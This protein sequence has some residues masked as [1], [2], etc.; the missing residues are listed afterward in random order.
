MAT[1]KKTLR[2]AALSLTVL[3]IVT[4]GLTACGHGD[5]KAVPT[6]TILST[7]SMGSSGSASVSPSASS[8]ASGAAGASGNGTA[9]ATAGGSPAPGS[10]TSAP[11]STAIFTAPDSQQVPPRQD[12]NDAATIFAKA[13]LNTDG[14]KD[15][16]LG[17]L[18]PLISAE[19]LDEFRTT[20]VIKIP[21]VQ[22][23]LAATRDGSNRLNA[24]F[25]I[26]EA[27]DNKTIAI[28]E[29]TFQPDGKWQIIKLGSPTK[30]QE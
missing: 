11:T 8:A 4:V 7:A 28:G 3:S 23:G 29:E 27:G 6:P 21:Q 10:S 26:Y 17:R 24:V 19:L 13:W 15:A 12:P 9:S 1:T 20:D 18:K 14:G 16:W 22:L 2:K 5:T 30:A 25:G